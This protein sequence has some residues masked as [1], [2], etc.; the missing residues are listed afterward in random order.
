MK[1]A[2]ILLIFIC[3]SITSCKKEKIIYKYED[4][5]SNELKERKKVQVATELIPGYEEEKKVAR[6]A[7]AEL[8]KG[9]LLA[10]YLKIKSEFAEENGRQMT[11][12]EIR[13]FKNEIDFDKHIKELD[14]IISKNQ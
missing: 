8:E 14:D 3:I 7:L 5:I 6:T 2:L 12:N 13:E 11:K 10:F 1:K 4:I 9:E